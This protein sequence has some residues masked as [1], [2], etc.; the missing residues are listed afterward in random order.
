MCP[1]PPMNIVRPETNENNY[2]QSL[3]ATLKRINKYIL[4]VTNVE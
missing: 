1:S 4:A 3:K 2:N